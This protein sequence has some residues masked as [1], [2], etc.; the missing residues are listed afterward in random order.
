MNFDREAAGL[1][2]INL[3]TITITMEEYKELLIIKGKYEELS[4]LH[5]PYVY[6]GIR[7][8]GTDLKKREFNEPYK[9]TCEVDNGCTRE[10]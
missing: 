1:E 4:R 2:P 6:T 10:Y 9:V 8:N 5:H 3:D 7:Y